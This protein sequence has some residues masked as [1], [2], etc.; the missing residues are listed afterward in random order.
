[1]HNILYSITKDKG[2]SMKL[3]EL[4]K[5]QSAFIQSVATDSDNA[6]RLI[7]LGFSKGSKVVAVIKGLTKGLTA[8]NTKN[9]LIALR[10]D[11]ASNI[12][13]IPIS[14]ETNE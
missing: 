9:T 4:M 1:M 10:D 2:V 6:Q 7:E 13:I 3:N 11:T 14:E 5:G 12:I 8:Y